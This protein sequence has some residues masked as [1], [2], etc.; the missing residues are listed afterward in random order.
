[1]FGRRGSPPKPGEIRPTSVEPKLVSERAEPAAP[2][3]PDVREV[4]PVEPVEER[5]TVKATPSKDD[6]PPM[7]STPSG[8]DVASEAGIDSAIEPAA[9]AAPPLAPEA[10]ANPRAQLFADLATLLMRDPQLKSLTIADLE[11]LLGPA[12]ATGQAATVKVRV[13]RGEQTTVVTAGALWAHVSGEVDARL[14]ADK[15]SGA[16]LRMGAADW[17]GGDQLWLLAVL[18]PPGVDAAVVSELDKQIFKG[19]PYKRFRGALMAASAQG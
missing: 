10:A 5:V 6:E 2:E 17:R 1:M 8:A 7:V 12:L 4:K 14:A 13:S 11:W 18:G 3:L 16:A 9:P 19:R 15:L